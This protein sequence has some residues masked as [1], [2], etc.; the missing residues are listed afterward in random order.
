MKNI[1]QNVELV[2]NNFDELIATK[3]ES[4][5]SE[6]KIDLN[7]SSNFIN[8]FGSELNNETRERLTNKLKMLT[9]WNIDKRKV[10]GSLEELN[11]SILTYKNDLYKILQKEI[12]MDQEVLYNL[13]GKV[14]NADRYENVLQTT[15]SKI[16]SELKIRGTDKIL[17]KEDRLYKAALALYILNNFDN[18]IEN[19][20]GD[21]IKTNPLRKNKIDLDLEKYNFNSKI[22]PTQDWIGS[23]QSKGSD[24]YTNNIFDAFISSIPNGNGGY[25]SNN[26]LKR[27]FIQINVKAQSNAIISKRFPDKRWGDLLLS[28][29]NV[30][31][32]WSMLIDY[33]SIDEDLKVG[34][35]N[36]VVTNLI[37]GLR[38]FREDYIKA[39][40]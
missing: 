5:V 26:D 27:I 31:E 40:D 29:D 32:Q 4:A 9:I 25:I 19:L 36:D 14:T 12:S 22:F 35:G 7:L 13:M 24:N 18:V 11:K 6:A 3:S 2:Q 20:V 10:I 16:V 37:V 34:I 23:I 1:Q 17:S 15:Y 33:L 21:V 39:W 30:L 8:L 38:S 28:S